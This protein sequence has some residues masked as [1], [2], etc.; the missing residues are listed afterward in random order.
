MPVPALLLRVLLCVTLILNGSG[1]AVASTA[2]EMG[3]LSDAHHPASAPEHAAMRGGSASAGMPCHEEA[4]GSPVPTIDTV[5]STSP[6]PDPDGPAADPDCCTS[7]HCVCV[8]QL[9]AAVPQAVVRP[10]VA[11]HAPDV[12]AV[13]S[14][15]A[16]PLIPQPIRP[17]IA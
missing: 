10:P 3:H 12:R 2:M 4:A 14:A 1:Y 11:V 6:Q 17:P 9:A 16:A 7:S 13:A 5:G 8:Q 15:R